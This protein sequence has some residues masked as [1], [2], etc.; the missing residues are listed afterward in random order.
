MPTDDAPREYVD[1]FKSL[2]LLLGARLGSGASGNVYRASQARLGRDVAVKFFDHPGVGD[3][4]VNRKRFEREAKLLAQVQHP[5]IPYVLSC[6]KMVLSSKNE[7][8]Y[9][10]MQFIDGQRMDAVI[11]KG[12]VGVDVASSFG[13]QILGALS[14]VHRGKIVHRDVKP[15]NIMLDRSGHCYL[16][17]FSIGVSLSRSPGLTRV[18]GDGKT[19]GTWIYASPEQLAG[20]EV[21]HRTDLFSLGLVLFELLTGRRVGR[22]GLS[23]LDLAQVPPVMREVLRRACRM[24]LGE[25][26][27]SADEF[28]TELA[29]FEQAGVEW[30][31]PRDALCLSV[32]C[33][34]TRWDRNGYYSGPHVVAG[35]EKAY[36][37]HSGHPLVFPCVKCGVPYNGSQFCA[38]CGSAHYEVPVC[39]RCG[40]VLR[41]QDRQTNTGVDGCAGCSSDDDI[42][43]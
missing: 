10:V 15:E 26:F 42:P 8:P 22:P 41:R 23:E 36:C 4:D 7:V 2:N 11:H 34:G 43:F 18:T 21:D 25:R 12:R 19:P 29:R 31:E 3:D 32:L 24:E 35:T 20:R 6:G 30:G 17:D 16:I 13:K 28:R 40:V 33:P 1:Y 38:D 9:I 39:G 14:C 37:Q 27:Q 5:S